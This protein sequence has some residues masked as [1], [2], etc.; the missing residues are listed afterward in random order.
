MPFMPE[1]WKNGFRSR[2]GYL[3]Q[4]WCTSYGVVCVL[5]LLMNPHLR[6][7]FSFFKGI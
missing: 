4:Y 5:V 2:T 7:T 1:Q 3:Q 6:Q